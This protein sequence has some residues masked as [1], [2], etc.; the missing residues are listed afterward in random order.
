MF[1]VDWWVGDLIFDA[2]VR[3]SD[4]VTV[5][6]STNRRGRPTLTLDAVV[7]KGLG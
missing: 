5:Y 7:R 3:K 4:M 1:I 6:G 2:V